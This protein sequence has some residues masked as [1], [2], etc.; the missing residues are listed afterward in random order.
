MTSSLSDPNNVEGTAAPN[1]EAAAYPHRHSAQI[2]VHAET[3]THSI[4]APHLAG[5]SLQLLDMLHGH[6]CQSLLMKRHLDPVSASVLDLICS[7]SGLLH[8]SKVGPDII[9]QQC[10]TTANCWEPSAHLQ[11]HRYSV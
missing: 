8:K 3:Q 7:R 1:L 4:S 9:L 10:A 6:S 2:E 5:C 11:A